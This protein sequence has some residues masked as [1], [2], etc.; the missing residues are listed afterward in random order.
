MAFPTSSQWTGATLADILTGD[1]SIDLNSASAGAFKVAMFTN[2]V[3]GFANG[4]ADNTY[5]SGAWSANEVSGTGYTTAG[6]ALVSPTLTTTANKFVWDAADTT[7]SGSSISNARGAI[8]Y[9]VS[10]GRVLV[11]SDFDADYSTTSGTFTIQWDATNGIG[12]AS[13]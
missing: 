3:T 13:F 11:V 7:W 6:A 10:T 12:Y 4:D 1:A 2:S 8:V 5:G 9:H